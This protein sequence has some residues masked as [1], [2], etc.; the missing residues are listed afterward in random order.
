MIIINSAQKQ[1]EIIDLLTN[2][3]QGD[4][5]FTFG[6]RAGMRLRFTT[7]QPDEHAA[8]QTARE[9]IKAAPWGKTI[10]FTITTGGPA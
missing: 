9:L 1:S 10:Y 4:T 2:Y 3:A 8:G 6:D 7:N 5:R